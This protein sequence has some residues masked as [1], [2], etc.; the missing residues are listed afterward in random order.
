[1]ISIIIS[2]YKESYFDQLESNIRDTI[3]LPYEIIKIY[4]PGL[5]GL[6]EAYNKGASKAC[7]EILCFAHED[8]NIKTL[9][10]GKIV[11]DLFN[12]ETIG[13]LGVAGSKYKT[14]IPSGWSFMY[15]DHTVSTCM[16]LLQN[17]KNSKKN[18]IHAYNNP[19]DG[20]TSQVAAIDGMWFCTRKKIVTDLHFDETTFKGFHGYDIDFSLQVFQRYQVL[21][22]YEILIEHFSEGT[23][24]EI[25]M[26]EILK[27]HIKWKSGLP[28]SSVNVSKEWRQTEE[29]KALHYFIEQM[30]EYDVPLKNLFS[31]LLSNKI[32]AVKIL[33]IKGFI[34]MYIKLTLGYYKKK[35]L[36]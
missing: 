5:M 26:T 22:T 7:Y 36:F 6:C 8:I 1:M 13:L 29:Y 20:T 2:S 19:G 35:P 12:D 21:V 9:N 28:F 34:K 14:Y 11:L 24:N 3:G 18:T 23:F 32:K 4:N 17:F 15:A 30:N 31:F 10:W 27:L 33:G 25:W 16:N